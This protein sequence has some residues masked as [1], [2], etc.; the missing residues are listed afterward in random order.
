MGHTKTVRGHAEESIPSRNTQFLFKKIRKYILQCTFL[1]FLLLAQ[2]GFAVESTQ[3]FHIIPEIS[4]FKV[5]SPKNPI[6]V[7]KLPLPWELLREMLNKYVT[8]QHL[9]WS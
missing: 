2:D 4:I 1:I 9:D 3:I 8:N 5:L 7:P 6:F